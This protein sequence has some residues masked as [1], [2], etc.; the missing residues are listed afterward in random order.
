MSNQQ[1][2]HYNLWIPLQTDPTAK[3][4]IVILNLNGY[5]DTRECLES[6]R[7]V[8]YAN[9]EVILVDNGSSD[10]SSK[11]LKSEFPEVRLLMSQQ[12]LGFGGGCNLGIEDA[13]RHGA[14]FVLL[15]NNDTIVDP[16]F[17]RILIE[18]GETDPQI[19]ILGPKIY[20]AS[21]PKRIWF[22]GGFVRLKSGR[23]GH[24]GQGRI[25]EDGHFAKMEETGWITGC[26]LLIKSYVFQEI[27]FL[28]SELFAYS[29][30]ADFCLRARSAGYKCIFMP[31]AKV[32]HKISRT[33]GAQSPFALYLGTRNQLIWISRYVPYPYR[34]GAL[35][36][37]L[38]KKLGRAGLLFFHHP[39]S[40]F[41]VFRGMEA[42]FTNKFGPPGKDIL[43]TAG[44][45]STPP[46]AQKLSSSE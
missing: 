10:E 16:D 15:L 43:P 21:D 34:I 35:A 28:D 25:D 11:H 23:F 46:V 20:Y 37:T 6:I 44:I 14:D 12:N 1:V 4:S 45:I 17:L 2:T 9:L 41:A 24:F 19:G 22:A 36:F 38:I 32:W 33:S 31:D 13:L 30:D 3:V 40:A 7:H 5:E 27:G 29:E 18:T 42:F 8:R 39:G 26:A